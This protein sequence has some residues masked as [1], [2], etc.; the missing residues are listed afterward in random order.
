MIEQERGNSMQTALI[1]HTGFVGSTLMRQ[2]SYSHY[3]NSSNIED[4]MGNTY[5]LVVCAGAPAVKWKANQNPEEDLQ[6]IQRLMSCLKEVK[7]DEFIL[8][9]TVDVYRN[10][11]DV[12]ERTE[13]RPELT[14]PYGRHRFYLE[15]FVTDTFQTCRVI[16]LPGL[17]GKGL[18][19]NFIYDLMNNNA[20]HLTH[21]KSIFQFYDMSR[22]ASD[23]EIVR[24]AGLRIVNF[25]TEPVSAAEL[26]R[27][28]FGVEFTN[29]TE[30][31]PVHYN[32]CSEHIDHFAPGQKYMMSKEQVFERIREFVKSEGVRA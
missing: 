24:S 17:F 4:I 26:A 15:Q 7:A 19:K 21:H 23:L 18:K 30:K 5:D 16:R 9:S 25:A 6:S 12:T 20:L 2:Q 22:L 10:P 29:E 28:C 11:I 32:M 8:I 31:P 13:I 14:E 27:E 3:F 1:G